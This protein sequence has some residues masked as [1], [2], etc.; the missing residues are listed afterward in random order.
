MEA[1][2]ASDYPFIFI[3]LAFYV[4]YHAHGELAKLLLRH[5]GP[6]FVVGLLLLEIDFALF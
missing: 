1:G 5:F 2:I 3:Y 6:G 4:F